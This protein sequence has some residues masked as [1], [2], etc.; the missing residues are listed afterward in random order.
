[1]F[2]FKKI[3]WLQTGF[4][5]LAPIDS[6]SLVG[7]RGA[8]VICRGTLRV[9]NPDVCEHRFKARNSARNQ[10]AKKIVFKVLIFLSLFSLESIS[11]AAIS[12]DP[13]IYLEGN[14]G[15]AKVNE[16]VLN[17]DCD[18]SGLGGNFNAG[19]KFNP[20][21]ALEVGTAFYPDVLINEGNFLFDFAAKGIIP[22][23]SGFSFFGKLGVALVHHNIDPIYCNPGEVY[24]STLLI[25][26]G[27]GY[28]LT[29]NL[30]I[31][32]QSSGTNKVESSHV[33][34]MYLSTLGLT[35]T[36]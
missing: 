31:T 18:N 16:V 22:T 14:L 17:A 6:S 8:R 4:H 20:N 1:M 25:G 33:P 15:I 35:Y 13:G 2:Y 28:A 26:L 10:D 21:F 3:Y 32:I 19:Y 30:E 34:A 7:S 11:Y 29:H 36:F 24:K 27:I 23:K 9:P 12:K 5:G